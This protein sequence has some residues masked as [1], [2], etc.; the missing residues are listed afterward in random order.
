[1]VFPTT[2]AALLLT[3]PPADAESWRC[4]HFRREGEASLIVTRGLD[5]DG[6]ALSDHV[7]WL[8]EQRTGDSAVRWIRQGPVASTALPWRLQTR[9][10]TARLSLARPARRPVWLVLRVDGRIAGRRLLLRQMSDLPSYDRERLRASATFSDDEPGQGPVPDLAGAAEIVITAEEE[11]GETLA[12]SAIPLPARTLVEEM[13]A[14]VAPALVADAADYRT[15]CRD[16]SQP[17]P[18]PPMPPPPR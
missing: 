6:R 12:R 4:L 18:V 3:P 8:P 14:Q 15:L 2:L 11:G 5:A 10:V 13:I 9:S 17:L 7:L 1:M 16:T